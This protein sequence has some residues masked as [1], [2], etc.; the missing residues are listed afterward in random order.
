MSLDEGATW[1]VADI[2]RPFPPNRHGMHW[3]WIFWSLPVPVAR[4]SAA[5][6]IIC[7]AWDN[8]TNT[9]PV[10]FTWNLMGMANNCCFR[11]KIHSVVDS[12]GNPKLKFEHPTLAGAQKGGWMTKDSGKP[13]S[14]GFGNLRKFLEE[15]EAAEE[16]DAKKQEAAAPKRKGKTA[17]SGAKGYT[18]SEIEK[19]RWIQS[20][21][22][23]DGVVATS[24]NL[25]TGHPL[26]QVASDAEAYTLFLA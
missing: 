19:V 26:L 14:A 16:A 22:R 15:Q 1:L 25:D 3:C 9:Q 10:N 4:L 21:A 18:M 23:S 17:N 2:N 11:V 12:A 13:V 20:E 7:R 8:H 24:N 6:S 5:P